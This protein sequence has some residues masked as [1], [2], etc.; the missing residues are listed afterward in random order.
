MKHRTFKIER[1]LS[2]LIL[3]PFGASLRAPRA[4]R[5]RSHRSCASASLCACSLRLPSDR[6]TRPRDLLFL[7]R[8]QVRLLVFGEGEQQVHAASVWLDRLHQTHVKLK[9]SPIAAL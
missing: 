1:T 8:Y 2:V 5:R 4:V 7:R 6:G 3:L 9:G